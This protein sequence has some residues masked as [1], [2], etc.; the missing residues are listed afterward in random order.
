MPKPKTPAIPDTQALRGFMEEYQQMLR[1]ADRQLKKVLALDPRK[2]EFWDALTDLAPQVTMIGARADT[3]W[4]E[5]VDLVDR[6]P[7]D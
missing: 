4:E 7:E 5:I 3:I 2:E 6:L 1:D